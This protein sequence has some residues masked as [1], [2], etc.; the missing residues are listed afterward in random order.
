MYN[1][2]RVNELDHVIRKTLFFPVSSIFTNTIIPRSY[3]KNKYP[4]S[5][6]SAGKGARPQNS[7]VFHTSSYAIYSGEREAETS[8]GLLLYWTVLIKGCIISLNN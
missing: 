6:F 3:K 8:K 4:A 7:V 1:S 2:L 5:Y